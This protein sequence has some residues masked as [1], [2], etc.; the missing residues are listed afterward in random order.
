M[1]VPC[2]TKLYEGYL[3]L[4]GFYSFCYIVILNVWEFEWM[5]LLLYDHH[6]FPY[7]GI[8]IHTKVFHYQILISDR[9]L[10][11]TF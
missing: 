1:Y 4:F 2:Q 6:R 9:Q 5:V 8:K 10:S 7:H 11:N 3:I